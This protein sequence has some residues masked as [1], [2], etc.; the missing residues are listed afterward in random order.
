M[1][2]QPAQDMRI[3]GAS[4]APRAGQ[5]GTS[6]TQQRFAK[7]VKEAARLK[8]AVR[9]WSQALPGLHRAIGEHEHLAR[10]HRGVVADLV[11][12][13]DRSF[14]HPS[15]SKRERAFLRRILCDTARDVLATGDLAD[16]KAIYNRHS[17]GDFDAEAAAAEAM[18]AQV[19]RGVL[20]TELGLDFGRAD[21]RTV[22]E[23]RAAALA[24]VD[25]LEREEARREEAAEARR[26]RRKRPAREVAAEARREA[27]R[28]QVGKA[29]QDVYRKLAV[30]L[31]PDLEQ[32]PAERAR[33]T[34]LM[35]Q[36]N[37]AY[38]QKDLL[39]LLELQLRFEQIDEAQ[40][41]ALAGDRL[42]R[43][44]RLLAE[45]VAQLKEELAEIELPWRMQLDAPTGRLAPARVRRALDEDL[46]GLAF[47]LASARADLQRLADPAALKAW[48]QQG[49]LAERRVRDLRGDF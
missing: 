14:T 33:K 48:I 6:R 21:L 32:D 40:L 1:S 43:Y 25:E 26:T 17:R 4:A 45:Q 27:E 5:A 3:V 16:V 15:L 20:E 29:L 8:D 24:Q 36:V 30:A 38:E 39:A 7:L 35:Q 23:L 46:R 9:A 42:E 18:Q 2:E 37:V 22:E 41:G 47:E 44:N 13:L 11:R 10:T 49:L 12:L 31:H 34:L 28:A 19:M